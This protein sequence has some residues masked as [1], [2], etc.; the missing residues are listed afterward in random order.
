MVLTI[1]LITYPWQSF[2]SINFTVFLLAVLLSLY[3]Q[4][5][6]WE[7]LPGSESQIYRF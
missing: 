7:R 2:L 5:L 4:I 3:L 6:L 1:I